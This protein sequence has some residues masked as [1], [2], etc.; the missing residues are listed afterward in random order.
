MTFNREVFFSYIRK[1][2]FGNRMSPSQIDGVNRIL[3]YKERYYSNINNRWLA[4]ILASVFHETGGRMQPIREAYG[5]SDKDSIHRL[6]KAYASGKL[7][8][9][10]SPY[11]RT[12]YFGRGLIQIT[13]KDNYEKW[14]LTSTPEK[15][16]EWET[17]LNIVFEGMIKGKFR[18]GKRLD[19]FFNE[20]THNPEGARDIV[21]D[22]NDKPVLIAQYY[23]HFLESFKASYK[24]EK[25]EEIKEEKVLEDSPPSRSPADLIVVGTSTAGNLVSAITN[26]WAVVALGIVI[27][28]VIIGAYFYFRKKEKYEFGF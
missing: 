19:K 10:K 7:P 22:P 14:G 24:E 28:A 26:P 20:A 4:Y 1:A 23:N 12:G 9:V 25:V 6:N 16:L 15:A 18:A 17:S 11:W 13:H 21:N 2:P 27:T 5:T 8:S 3:D